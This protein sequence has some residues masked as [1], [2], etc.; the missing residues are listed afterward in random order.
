MKCIMFFVLLIGYPLIGVI[1]AA[2]I[3]RVD[4]PQGTI[5]DFDDYGFAYPM[6]PMDQA[7][8]LEYAMAIMWP[9]FIVVMI[10]GNALCLIFD[11]GRKFGEKIGSRIVDR[12]QK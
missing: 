5:I 6:S 11:F 3:N 12:Y 1:L 10:I 8:S 9:M 7:R 4:P 2:I